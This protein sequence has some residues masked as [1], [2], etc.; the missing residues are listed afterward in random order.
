MDRKMNEKSLRTV[1]PKALG[2]EELSAVSGAGDIFSFA[3]P[4]AVTQLN[5]SAPTAVVAGNFGPSLLS[6]DTTQ[7]NQASV[8]Y[9]H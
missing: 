4:V 9:G 1:E 2:D 7:V 5:I 6:Q 8:S 3:S